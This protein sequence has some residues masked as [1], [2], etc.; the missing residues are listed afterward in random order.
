MVNRFENIALI[1]VVAHT[2]DT[3]DNYVTNLKRLERRLS[4]SKHFNID[5]VSSKVFVNR[6]YAKADYTGYLKE[7]YLDLT[8]LDVAMLCDEGFNWLGGF[9]DIACDKF[10]VTVYMDKGEAFK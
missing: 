2:D 1:P 4:S 9:S 5:S 3:Y 6:G 10:T 7:E 8:A